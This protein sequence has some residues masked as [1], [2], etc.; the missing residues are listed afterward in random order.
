M[1]AGRR[2]RAAAANARVGPSGSGSGS[3]PAA[4]GPSAVM[5]K[6]GDSV[7]SCRH[8]S[9]A[10][11]PA[12]T[13]TPSASAARCSSGSG[14]QRCWTS[15]TRSGARVGSCTRANDGGVSPMAVISFRSLTR[16]SLDTRLPRLVRV[17][18]P[19]LGPLVR[20]RS[21]KRGH[22][23]DVDRRDDR[24]AEV[25][26]RRGAALAAGAGRRRGAG[27]DVRAPSSGALSLLPVDPARRRGRPRCA[28]EHDGQGPGGAA[29][30]RSAT[31]SCGRG[32]SGS[33][34][35]R[36]SRGC[37]SA[38]KW[39]TSMRSGALGTRFA[40]PDGGGPRASGA[41]A[42][43]PA[44]PARAPALGARAARAERA[45]ARGDRRGPRQLGARGQADDLRGARGAA[46][47]RR[48][49]DDAVR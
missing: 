33:R 14:C 45:L 46:A 3:A 7:S 26:A 23:T 22:A 49:P 34:T 28:A 38:A 12:A 32:C 30:T 15:P 2:A 40:G 31:S 17:L 29:Q 4:C 6:Y 25:A 35:T 21:M 43:R 24:G 19:T 47:M 18:A 42:R 10:P 37:A 9:F 11:S 16:R 41:P 44:R 8:T 36:R 20:C 39:W 5:A 13:R 48:G 27:G 1:D